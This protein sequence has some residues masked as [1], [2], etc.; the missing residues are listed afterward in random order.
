MKRN[1]GG[2]QVPKSKAALQNIFALLGIHVRFA[3]APDPSNS[4]VLSCLPQ[5]YEENQWLKWTYILYEKD[6]EQNTDIV[7][8]IMDQEMGLTLPL[9]IQNRPS[10]FFFFFLLYLFTCSV[11]LLFFPENIRRMEGITTHFT[12]MFPYYSLLPF[13]LVLLYFPE[14]VV[15]ED[16]E[17]TLRTFTICLLSSLNKRR[18]WPLI[19][20]RRSHLLHSIWLQLA[21]IYHQYTLY[22]MQCY[23]DSFPVSVPLCSRH[24]PNLLLQRGY[25]HEN[26]KNDPL[27]HHSS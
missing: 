6:S 24:H 13:L 4:K 21:A 25:F 10:S 11:S 27:L 9:N 3:K 18:I 15:L 5:L 14:E 2:I 17:T 19:H 22:F 1:S 12:N 16:F 26:I 8:Q 20:V 23:F 7:L